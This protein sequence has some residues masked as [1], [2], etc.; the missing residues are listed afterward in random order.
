MILNFNAFRS[1]HTAYMQLFWVKIHSN[2]GFWDPECLRNFHYFPQAQKKE[3]K[4]H[5]YDNYA[6]SMRSL[7]IKILKDAWIPNLAI[8]YSS[9]HNY[10]I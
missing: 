5:E 6:I 4:N 9:I 3:N 1:Q 8:A 7:L 10:I 2:L